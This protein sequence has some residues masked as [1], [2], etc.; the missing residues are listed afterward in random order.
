MPLSTLHREVVRLDESGL[1]TSRPLGRNRLI[2]ANMDH[3]AA[4]ALA[5]L[6]KLT[7][8]PRVGVGIDRADVYDAADRAQTRLGIEINPVV[9]SV[10]QWKDPVDALVSQIEASWHTTVLDAHKSVGN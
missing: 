3:P 10:E 8:G 4:S 2:R 6:L 1:I 9:R 7:F 5:E